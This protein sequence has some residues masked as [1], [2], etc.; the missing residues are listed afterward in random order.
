[1]CMY[2]TGVF[3]RYLHIPFHNVFLLK[4]G[5]VQRLMVQTYV[6]TLQSPGV[7]KLGTSTRLA[8]GWVLRRR[9]AMGI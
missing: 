2:L 5:C 4:V 9:N 6:L 1:M 3:R 7:A 8:R